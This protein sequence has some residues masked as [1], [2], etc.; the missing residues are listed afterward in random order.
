MSFASRRA[1]HPSAIFDLVITLMSWRLPPMWWGAAHPRRGHRRRR[2]RS[3]A[4]RC[5]AAT[6]SPAGWAT[7]LLPSSTREPSDSGAPL[8]AESVPGA[9]HRAPRARMLRSRRMTRPPGRLFA[10]TASSRRSV[11][12]DRGSAAP[13]AR[14]VRCQH[15]CTSAP[16]PAQNPDA[17]SATGF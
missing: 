11:P 1:A 17:L 2:D 5:Q 13:A 6:S 7:L 12:Y 4:T 16:A 9:E 8:Q 10:A 15:L 3:R 14:A